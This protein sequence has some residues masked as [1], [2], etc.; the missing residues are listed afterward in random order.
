MG[1][2]NKV[3]LHAWKKTGQHWILFVLA[4]YHKIIIEDIQK[5]IDW[6]TG[7]KF[8]RKGVGFSN[9]EW[10]NYTLPI[11]WKDFNEEY[12]TMLRSE[13]NWERN[14][15]YHESFDKVIYLYRNPFDVLVS[16]YYYYEKDKIRQILV[17]K[18]DLEY[19]IR[20]LKVQLDLDILWRY[21]KEY[22]LV[23]IQHLNQG[24]HHGDII[25]SY[26]NL[27]KYPSLFRDILLLFYDY[28][29]EKS[30]Q[31]A[32]KFGGFEVIHEL[33]PHHAR[34][35]SI[36]QYKKVMNIEMIEYIKKICR[37]NLRPKLM[38]VLEIERY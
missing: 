17:A 38:E 32:L 31:K 7:A 2:N 15:R 20:P 33:N 22:L 9:K 8:A 34:D 23:Y 14:K 37:E 21:I 28:I 12:P 24:Y 3:L 6:D 26:E 18:G 13:A 29:H 5:P 16:L 25:L 10:D 4:N 11:E 30:F 35:G 1:R 36:Y 19:D 27:K